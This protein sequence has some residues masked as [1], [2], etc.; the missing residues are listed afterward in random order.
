LN[1]AHQVKEKFLKNQEILIQKSKSGEPLVEVQIKEEK[2][3]V[4]LEPAEQSVDD[5]DVFQDVDDSPEDIQE[6]K[7]KVEVPKKPKRFRAPKGERG[8][9][10]KPKPQQK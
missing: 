6:E 8:P 1:K 7:V 2:P 5:E 9:R 3:D 10:S 4:K